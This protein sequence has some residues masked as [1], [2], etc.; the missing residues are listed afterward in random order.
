MIDWHTHVLPEMDDGSRSVEESLSMLRALRE[1]GIDSV[2]ATPHF[3]AYDESVERFLERRACAYEK[4]QPYLTADLPK[5]T[6]GAEVR[7]YAGISRLQ[8]LDR[9][10]IQSTRLLLL[11]MPSCRWT[12]SMLRELR[13]LAN[14]HG[15]QLVI[16]HI[17]RYRSYQPNG[18]VEMLFESGILMQGNASFFEHFTERRTAMKLVRNGVLSFI[19]SDCHNMTSRPP[20][21]GK[22]YGHIAKN[23]GDDF[24]NRMTAFGSHWFS[25]N[26]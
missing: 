1:Q 18:T 12:E 25:E 15:R 13:E 10:K 8:E 7:Y 24:L 22:A 17:D 23:L 19:G 16:A 26:K 20:R 11:E 14:C 4:L 6:L 5:I 3:Y 2:I 21:I 9:L